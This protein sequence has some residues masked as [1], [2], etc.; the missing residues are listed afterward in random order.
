[1]FL[2]NFK[3]L[4]KSRNQYYYNIKNTYCKSSVLSDFTISRRKILFHMRKGT[5]FNTNLNRHVTGKRGIANEHLK[6]KISK[7]GR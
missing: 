1:M 5:L 2:Y 3:Y 6:R 4:Q 7:A